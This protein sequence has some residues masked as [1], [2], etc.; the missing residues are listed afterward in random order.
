MGTALAFHAMGVALRPADRAP[1]GQAR[2]R[3]LARRGA[4][5]SAL[6]LCAAA[7]LATLSTQAAVAQSALGAQAA[8]GSDLDEV[9]VTARRV[10]SPT[11]PA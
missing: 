11:F 2:L 6:A 1:A 5:R 10:C 3:L 4:R 9:L 8:V 7:T